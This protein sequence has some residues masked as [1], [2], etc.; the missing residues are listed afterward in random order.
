MNAINKQSIAHS[1]TAGHVTSVAMPTRKTA[2]LR[3]R[4]HARR[5]HL[6]SCTHSNPEV[7]QMRK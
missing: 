5:A 2:W 6:Q 1:E 7:I 4:T 3:A